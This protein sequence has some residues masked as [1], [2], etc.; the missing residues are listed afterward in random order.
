MAV[1]GLGWN[2]CLAVEYHKGWHGVDFWREGGFN[3]GFCDFVSFPISKKEAVRQQTSSVPSVPLYVDCLVKA[4][5][6][7]TVDVSVSRGL[8]LFLGFGLFSI[9]FNV[10]LGGRGFISSVECST[11]DCGTG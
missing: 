8:V 10:A 9:C 11:L 6:G 3:R 4:F 2:K 1:I 5:N 7:G